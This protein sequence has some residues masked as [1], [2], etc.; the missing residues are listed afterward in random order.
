MDKDEK[1]DRFLASVAELRLKKWCIFRGLREFRS[2]RLTTLYGTKE[3]AI[4]QARNLARESFMSGQ[5]DFVYFVSHIEAEIGFI[6][7][8]MFDRSI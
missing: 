1:K 4:E 6:G 2:C 5:S 8:E 7:S 3:E